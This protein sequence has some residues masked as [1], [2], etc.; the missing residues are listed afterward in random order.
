MKTNVEDLFQYICELFIASGLEEKDA[1]VVT[2]I[3]KRATLRGVG[4]HDIYDLPKRL[5]AIA[6][7]KVN[8]KP[9]IS[10]Q[11]SFQ[12][13]ESYDGDNGLG[14]LCSYYITA[15][16]KQLADKF[17][18]GFCNVSN[19]NHFLSASPFIEDMSEQGYV[20][21]LLSSAQ[22]VMSMPGSSKTVIGNNPL[23]FGAPGK[24][25][26]INF[27]S[28]MAYHSV[29]NLKAYVEEGKKIP[30]YTAVDEHGNFTTDPTEALKGAALPVG[31]H[32]G[33]G[34]AIIVELLTTILS[35]GVMVNE[36]QH[37][38]ELFGHHFHS[39]AAIVLK[40][41]GIVEMEVFK[42]RVE[43]L[44]DFMKDQ[45]ESVRLPGER[46]KQKKVH[47]YEE[48]IVITEQLRNELNE[49]GKRFGVDRKL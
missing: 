16:A 43:S 39:Q 17:G 11:S 45:N 40:I 34:W 22:P 4:H 12:A 18:I 21:L 36:K 27:D 20:T 3:Y 14:E 33:F 6:N 10:R 37:I 31:Y 46:S 1:K 23:G 42:E 26:N 49:W 7:E 29:G 30:S 28:S 32:K 47:Y 38:N 44:D 15:R 48:G 2:D 8:V 24:E 5:E 9:N 19:S 13:I 41:E 25:Y 35:G